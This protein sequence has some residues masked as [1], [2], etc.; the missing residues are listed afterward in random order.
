MVGLTTPE[1]QKASL[2]L[3][4]RIGQQSTE[5]LAALVKLFRD[6]IIRTASPEQLE[7]AVDTYL[8][9]L[10]GELSL[11]L[12]MENLYSI[13]QYLAVSDTHNIVRCDDPHNLDHKEAPDKL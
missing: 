3:I 13:S 11:R 5:E 9:Y 10:V 2:S 1:V 12:G 8:L 4:R 7:Q 6:R